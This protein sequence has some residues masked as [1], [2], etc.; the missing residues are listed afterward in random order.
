[1]FHDEATNSKFKHLPATK[2]SEHAIGSRDLHVTDRVEVMARSDDASGTIPEFEFSCVDQRSDVPVLG[3]SGC[4]TSSG[5]F[6]FFNIPCALKTFKK[7]FWRSFAV[8]A[9]VSSA[10]SSVT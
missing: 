9:I 1:M 4:G 3:C 6:A 10:A 2:L 7:K 8:S 5:T